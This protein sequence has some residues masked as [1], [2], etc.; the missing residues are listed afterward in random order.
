MR[1]DLSHPRDESVPR[2]LLFPNSHTLSLWADNDSVQDY[3]LAVTFI[4]A[5]QAK[6]ACLSGCI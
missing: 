3:K 5:Q 4:A 2:D 6:L 1:R